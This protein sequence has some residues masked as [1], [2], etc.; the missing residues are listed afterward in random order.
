[1]ASDRRRRTGAVAFSHRRHLIG[2]LVA[3]AALPVLL[4]GTTPV[5]A[6][7]AWWSPVGLRGQSITKV[8]AI[9]NAIMVRTGAGATLVS[10]D[11]GKTFTPATGT[12]AFPPAGT[13]QIGSA[14][15]SISS[16]GRV[17]YSANAA[18]RNTPTFDRGTPHLGAGA[19][20]LA[21][22]AALPGVVVAVS[23]DGTVWRRGQD[24]DWKQALLLLP[25]SL[26]QGV[27]RV[28]SVTAFTQPPSE[29]IYLGTDGY[30]VLISTDG[31]DDWIRAGPG[32]PDAVY[33]LSADSARNSL[34]AGTSDGLW[35]HVL[36]N[37]PAP[38]AYRDAALV[39]RWIGIGAVTLVAAAL[40]LLGMA[41]LVPRRA[42]GA[43]S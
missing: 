5:R 40:T 31:G 25:Q 23:T 14:V 9:G 24:G 36:Q 10:N 18:L 12:T 33:A 39:W 26:V 41:R 3:A 34:Y 15:W 30:A 16:D 13:V 8:S 2:A 42:D 21:A 4:L 17:G 1:M 7:D 19:D 11:A 38:P 20:L 6:A 43:T 35:V 37:L 22:P 28:T 29:A 32:L 27:P